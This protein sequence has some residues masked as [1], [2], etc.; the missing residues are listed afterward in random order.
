MARRRYDRR[1]VQP[2]R[3][4]FRHFVVARPRTGRA[5][6]RRPPDFSRRC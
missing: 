3:L 2:A 5:A 4:E 6:A 1:L